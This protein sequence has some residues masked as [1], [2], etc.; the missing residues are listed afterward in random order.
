[1]GRIT[2]VFIVSVLALSLGVGLE[3]NTPNHEAVEGEALAK[4]PSA[5]A[6][7]PVA[8]L[9]AV[10]ARVT[11]LE[12]FAEFGK[13]PR[14]R[15]AAQGGPAA[16]VTTDKSDYQPFDVVTITGRNWYPREVVT[17]VLEEDPGTHPDVT[18]YAAAD[19]QGRFSN[20][21]F[22][23]QPHDLGVTFTLTATGTVSGATAQ[24]TFTDSQHS[25][26]QPAA[27]LDQCR[28]GAPETPNNCL[29][30][31]GSAGWVNGNAGETNA[32][33]TEGLSIPYRAEL[34]NLP[35]DGTVITLTLGY[36]IKHSGRHAIDFLTH[37]QRLLP[38]P[39][40]LTPRRPS[41][42]MTA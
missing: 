1:M 9:L 23:V 24:T 10:R 35:T 25:G 8:S 18:L 26:G 14:A 36:D 22:I 27:N 42:L 33:Y 17:L 6:S 12:L 34:T 31:G 39:A 21:Q 4:V 5:R 16:T 15:A 7:L 13:V 30:F 37:Y 11:E 2:Q 28:N 32:H 3:A 19:D 38:I 20:D 40:S 41:F 29:D